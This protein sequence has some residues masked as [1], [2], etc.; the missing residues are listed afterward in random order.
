[1]KNRSLFS[2]VLVGLMM[3]SSLGSLRAQQEAVA[4][5]ET[6]YA[7][8]V[9]SKAQ[10]TALKER[11]IFRRDKEDPNAIVG[12]FWFDHKSFLAVEGVIFQGGFIVVIAA[13]LRDQNIC[14]F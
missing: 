6:E 13:S 12:G 11:F 14:F 4:I 5:E 9:F 7:P 1:M 2:K 8:P 10:L 3:I